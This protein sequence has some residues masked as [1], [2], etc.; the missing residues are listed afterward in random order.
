[1]PEELKRID[2]LPSCDS[3][4][5]A[6]E[7]EKLRHNVRVQ[8]PINIAVNGAE[9]STY[10]YS[11][12]RSYFVNEGATVNGGVNV[13]GPRRLPPPKLRLLENMSVNGTFASAKVIT[14]SSGAYNVTGDAADV[15]DLFGK[16]EHSLTDDEGY[17]GYDEERDVL[18]LYDMN[19]P[20]IR[21][22][23]LNSGDDITS[24][25]GG[26]GTVVSSG[27]NFEVYGFNVLD[28]YKIPLGATTY[29]TFY[30]DFAENKYI[31]ISTN[32]CVV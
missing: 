4:T 21:I 26:V 31:A 32:K 30:Y 3:P 11:N 19:T 14:W 15:Y 25:S 16:W 27:K 5:V 18:F 9:P 28:T 10:I 23:I 12:P 2:A 22:G 7:M 24:G 29:V 6:K 13:I 20:L 1:M 17:L 8:G